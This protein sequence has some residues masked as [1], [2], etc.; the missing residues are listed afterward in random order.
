MSAI[1]SWV[2]YFPSN[3]RDSRE[4]IKE[5]KAAFKKDLEISLWM[6][7]QKLKII[8]YFTMFPFYAFKKFG[9]WTYSFSKAFMAQPLN[10]SVGGLLD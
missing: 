6:L 8:I 7:K 9:I 3:P 2:V 4:G 1:L 5:L 10:F